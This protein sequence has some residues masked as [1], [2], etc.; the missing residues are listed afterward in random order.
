M[1]GNTSTLRFESYSK[2]AWE[3]IWKKRQQELR[4]SRQTSGKGEDSKQHTEADA[5]GTPEE[6]GKNGIQADQ[7][8]P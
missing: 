3:A 7:T 2:E 5:V 8:S 1:V 6:C 4:T